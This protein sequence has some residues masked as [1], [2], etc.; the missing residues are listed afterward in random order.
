MRV[1]AFVS[2]MF[3]VGVM[4]AISLPGFA[5]EAAPPEKTGL[6]IS[7]QAPAIKLSDQ[8]GAERT[9]E[10][11]AKDHDYLALVFYRSASW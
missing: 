8:T 5:Q 10:D 11:L 3:V 6:A 1:N 4:V 7:E 2:A 9:F